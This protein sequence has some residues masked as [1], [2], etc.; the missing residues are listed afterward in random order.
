[1]LQQHKQRQLDREA[2]RHKGRQQAQQMLA[3][4]KAE[5]ELEQNFK[6]TKQPDDDGVVLWTERSL[7]PG[8]QKRRARGPHLGRQ[9][10]IH[11]ATQTKQLER[12]A[13]CGGSQI[14]K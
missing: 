1:M 6:R 8:W 4:R 9:Y 11:T 7:P 13:P 12:P 5:I 3:D 2:Q 10:Y 14:S